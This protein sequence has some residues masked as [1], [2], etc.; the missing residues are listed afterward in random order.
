MWQSRLPQPNSVDAFLVFQQYKVQAHVAFSIQV[1][2]RSADKALTFV[3]ST[4]GMCKRASDCHGGP[5]APCHRW[6]LTAYTSGAG[7]ATFRQ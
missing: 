3:G 6:H 7:L 2:T 1:E 4:L 5:S